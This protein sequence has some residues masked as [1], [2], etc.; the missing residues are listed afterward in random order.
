[1]AGKSSNA[2]AAGGIGGGTVYA[3]VVPVSTSD[4]QADPNGPFQSLW[5]GVGGNV[6]VTT[7]AGQSKTL[8][9][10]ANG[11]F[12]SEQVTQVWTTGTTATDIL[13]LGGTYTGGVAPRS[14]PI[15][16][17]DFEDSNAD[18]I[19]GMSLALQ[20]TVGY[21]TGKLNTKALNVPSGKTATGSTDTALN[22]VA[23]PFSVLFW[24]KRATGGTIE[25][26]FKDGTARGWKANLGATTVTATVDTS[27]AN[28]TAT[29]TVTIADDTWAM[30]V[31]SFDGDL[32]R[33]N[34]NNRTQV[35]AVATTTGSHATGTLYIAASSATCAVDGLAIFNR[36]LQPSEITAHYNSGTGLPYPF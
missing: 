2:P 33:L 14:G 23:N 21:T 16:Y 10:C 7:V 26:S 18:S 34:V 24:A 8:I 36:C 11:S 25:V 27:G 12:V 19:A 1:M 22:F 29:D 35:T 31:L 4:T 13:G 20:L 30:I 28:V 17:W 5:V 6:K 32:V 3:T 15:R 9:G